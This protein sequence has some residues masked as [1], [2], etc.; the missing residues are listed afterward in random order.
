MTPGD[1]RLV[2]AL[3]AEHAAIFGYGVVGAKLETG[4]V[5]LAQQAESAHRTRRDTLIVRLASKGIAVP[6][7]QPSYAL[8]FAV[9][10]HA[11]ALRLAVTLEE[12]AAAIWRLALPDTN[13]DERRLALDALVDCAVRATRFRHAG[14]TTPVTVAF[15]GKSA[16]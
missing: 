5:E 6:A 14:G 12:R 4:T 15:P 1:Q 10:D 9:T 3:Q 11:T 13:G 16:Q 2:A 7:A 8:P